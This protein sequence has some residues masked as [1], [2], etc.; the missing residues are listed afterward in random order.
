MSGLPDI[1]KRLF[2]NEEG[3]FRSGWRVL[4]FF[5]L[6]VIATSLLGVAL[7]VLIILAPPLGRLLSQPAAPGEG[8][9]SGELIYL[10]SGQL[11]NVAATLAATAVCARLLER[12]SLAS[13]GYKRHRGWLRD[14]S[15][16]SLV[17][18]ASLGL[19]VALAAA[20]GA[21]AFEVNAHDGT[22]LTGGFVTLFLFFLVSG[23]FEELLFRGFAFQA[24]THNLGAAAAVL[25]TSTLFGLAHLSNDNASTFSTVNTILAG[26]W[27]GVAYL[28]TR[29][30][31]LATALHYSW[32]FVTV[33]VFGLPVSGISTLTQLAWLRGRDLPPGWISGGDYGPEGG[34]AATLALILSTLLIWKGGLLKPSEEMLA[35]IRHGSVGPRPGG[36]PVD[37][38]AGA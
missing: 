11:I 3:E 31:W 33:F 10:M 8:L 28:T 15:L 21:V 38:E 24:L 25:I 20:F 23:A 22:L 37:K 6:Y 19:A 14:F 4:V 29:S 27:L 26:V 7:R 30:L 34:A 5:I 12:R 36:A 32:N 18:A 13:V 1:G 2:I 9:S 35:A 17:G 16:G